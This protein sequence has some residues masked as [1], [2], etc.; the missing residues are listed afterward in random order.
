[1]NEFGSIDWYAIVAVLIFIIFDYITGL[2]KAVKNQNISSSI[3]REGLIHKVSFVLI[4]VLGI[5]CEVIIQHIDIGITIP[6][7]VP[8]CVYI[9]LTEVSSIIENIMDSGFA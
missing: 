8:I 4:M 2:I 1:M 9:T 3:M 5:L 6:L 7:V